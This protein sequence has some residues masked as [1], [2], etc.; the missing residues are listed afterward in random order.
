M[1]FILAGLAMY[2]FVAFTRKGASRQPVPW[3][4]VVVL[5][6]FLFGLNYILTYTAETH[7]SR[8]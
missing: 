6:A 2:A 7:V 3:K 1:R 4:L 5:A 8:G